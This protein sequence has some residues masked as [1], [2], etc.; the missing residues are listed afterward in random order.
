MKAADKQRLLEENDIEVKL[1]AVAQALTR[2]IEVLELK[3]KIES[4]RSRR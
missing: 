3:G 2:E 4:E 1:A